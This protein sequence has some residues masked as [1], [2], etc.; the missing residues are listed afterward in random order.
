MQKTYAAVTLICAV[1]LAGSSYARG[2]HSSG[3]TY[4]HSSKAAPGISRDSHGKIARSRT[5]RSQFQHSSPCPSTGKRPVVV[6]AT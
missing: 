6:L 1:T 2:S 3:H 4:S 5:A